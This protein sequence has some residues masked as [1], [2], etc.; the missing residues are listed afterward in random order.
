[1]NLCDLCAG[2]W[3]SSVL[4]SVGFYTCVFIHG[5]NNEDL[6]STLMEAEFK[7]KIISL[8]RCYMFTKIIPI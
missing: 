3:C 1:M 4:P 6:E 2:L 7:K 5:E 8:I